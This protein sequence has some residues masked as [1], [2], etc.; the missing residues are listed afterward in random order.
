VGHEEISQALEHVISIELSV[1]HDVEALPTEFVDDRQ[2]PGGTTIV[3][4]VLHKIIGPDRM[5]TGRPEPDT[6]PVI[7]P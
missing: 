7:E 4:A 2:N 3:R 1:N 5:A 6:R